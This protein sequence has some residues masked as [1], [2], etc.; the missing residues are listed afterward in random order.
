[1]R[2]QAS[3]DLNTLERAMR[4]YT[5]LVTAVNLTDAAQLAV[6]GG[7]LSAPLNA[8]V[9]TALTST[10]TARLQLV[11]MLSDAI[12]NVGIFSRGVCN[13]D[14]VTLCSINGDCPGGPCVLL[15]QSRCK[16]S[17]LTVCSTSSACAVGDECLIDTG[18]FGTLSSLLSAAAT[19]P[20]VVA[21]RNR[22]RDTASALS[23]NVSALLGGVNASRAAA[24]G[25]QLTPFIAQLD[26]ALTQAALLNCT[27]RAARC[28]SV[29]AAATQPP[30]LTL[31]P[32]FL[33]SCACFCCLRRSGSVNTFVA[34]CA[35][36]CVTAVQRAVSPR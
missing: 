3:I 20:D 33:P 31:L 29:P 5:S 7:N 36:V 28:V 10:E 12:V 17:Q 16:N 14:G 8:S 13:I 25:V 23:V 35:R 1:M 6:N 18:T 34:R 2:V 11:V 30:R 32:S 26:D 27:A 22:V 19:V 24:S 15:G 4:N 9:S 21:A